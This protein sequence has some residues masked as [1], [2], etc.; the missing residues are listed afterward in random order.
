LADLPAQLDA[1]ES[2]VPQFGPED[3]P[4]RIAT[5]DLAPDVRALGEE[6]IR[7]VEAELEAILN[8]SSTVSD[9]KLAE[10]LRVLA[11]IESSVLVRRELMGLGTLPVR[12]RVS[13]NG[14]HAIATKDG[15]LVTALPTLAGVAPGEDDGSIDFF[16]SLAGAYRVVAVT[17]GQE[18]VALHFFGDVDNSVVERFKSFDASHAAVEKEHA[19]FEH[20]AKAFVE[21]RWWRVW[22]RHYTSQISEKCNTIYSG[23]SF[24]YLK[25]AEVPKVVALMEENGVYP[26]LNNDA[27]VVTALAVLGIASTPGVS[28]D[29]L[30]GIFQF[31][32]LKVT[33]LQQIRQ[34][35]STNGF[36]MVVAIDGLLRSWI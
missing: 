8:P 15:M 4:G 28:R 17:R 27:D 10:I 23:W 33:H 6:R 36:P 12:I 18:L 31:H 29:E 26:I 21:A 16:A 1:F 22:L 3:Q 19:A 9:P 32:G 24:P 25:E 2:A 7:S 11:H 35:E 14:H 5:P 20:L 30:L 13:K 34:S